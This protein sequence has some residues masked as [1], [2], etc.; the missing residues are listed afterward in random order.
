MNKTRLEKAHQN[1]YAQCR[2]KIKKVCYS[3]SI[4]ELKFV[5]DLGLRFSNEVKKIGYT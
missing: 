3:R 1:A 4:S 5:Q 2:F